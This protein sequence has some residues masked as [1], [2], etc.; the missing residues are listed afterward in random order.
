VNMKVDSAWHGIL[1]HYRYL[2]TTLCLIF[3]II[4]PHEPVKSRG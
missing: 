2:R 1:L 4:V 3:F